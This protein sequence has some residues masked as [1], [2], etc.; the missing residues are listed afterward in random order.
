MSYCDCYGIRMYYLEYTRIS[1]SPRP[2]AYCEH[3]RV[4]VECSG[5]SLDNKWPHATEKK[6]NEHPVGRKPV[7]GRS[8]QIWKF[9]II[10]II[11]NYRN[12]RIV[13]NIDFEEPFTC[14]T[15][16]NVASPTSL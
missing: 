13:K 5:H 4:S 8:D 1:R 16:G 9:T 11:R 12:C 3:G 7:P 10:K 14:T 6:E 15:T 2:Y